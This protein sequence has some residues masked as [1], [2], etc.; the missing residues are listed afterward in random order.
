MVNQLH[1]K[2]VPWDD[3]NFRFLFGNEV[4]YHTDH[5]FIFYGI[6]RFFKIFFIQTF[7]NPTI[8]QTNFLYT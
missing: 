4:V 8:T 1:I 5:D 6:F 7:M 2:A 3:I